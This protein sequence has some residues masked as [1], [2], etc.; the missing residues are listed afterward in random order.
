MGILKTLTVNGTTYNVTPVVP[1]SSVTLL[2]TAWE[3]SG[4]SYSQVV[5]IPGV[6]AHTM[7]DLQPTVKQQ[8]EFLDKI[9]TF[10]AE[11][12]WG[13]VTVYAIGDKP[14]GNH[15]I[16]TTL[17]EVETV[18]KIRGNTVGT[19]LPRTDFNQTDSSKADYLHGRGKIV[20]TVN[21]VAPD[22]NG[23]VNVTV[24]GSG[25]NVDLT[26]YVKSVNGIAPDKNGNVV[27]PGGS[28]ESGGVTS[29][30]DL[31][32]KPFYTGDPVETEVFNLSTALFRNDDPIWEQQEQIDDTTYLWRSYPSALGKVFEVGKE[33]TVVID[34]VEYKTTAIDGTTVDGEPGPEVALGDTEFFGT[35]S[36]PET[37]KY[38]IIEIDDFGDTY[39]NI[40]YKGE[41]AP[42][43]F[44]VLGIKPEI[45]KIDPKYLPDGGVGYTTE[46]EYGILRDERTFEVTNPDFGCL[47][48]RNLALTDGET[49]HV[50]FN[51][52][53]Y[54]CVAYRD[55]DDA[56]I[57]HLGG[58]REPFKIQSQ[59]GWCRLYP[60]E[61]GNHAVKIE[62]K[63]GLVYHKIDPR[64][65]P[66]DI[67]TGEDLDNVLE[68]VRTM[69]DAAGGGL[70]RDEVQTMIDTTLGVI[71]NGT[72]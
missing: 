33:Y 68:E 5:E 16:Q 35:D 21:G 30:N 29:W 23:N 66:D 24:P 19:P 46:G 37:F 49:Y 25:G 2:A 41:S 62:G 28:G 10:V 45:V 8:C 64:F 9:L 34:G 48:S 32:D 14:T 70:S 20:Q 7:V 6:T 54:D 52:V 53:E 51:G 69:I 13:V 67:V 60:T 50:T 12:D 22:E 27:L 56:T 3:G 55:P 65:L 38:A 43:E 31:T 57:V 42:K 40:I 4:G 58:D 17:T 63:Q 44:R 59:F 47:I 39:F 36:V 26:D 1:A 61:A 15:T 18:G 72:Y 71:E 11:N